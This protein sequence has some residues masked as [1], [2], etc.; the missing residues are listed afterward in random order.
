MRCCVAISGFTFELWCVDRPSYF[1]L[2]L[3]LFF[4]FSI[5]K[6]S[7]GHKWRHFLFK[8]S[9]Q[10]V[11]YYG[12]HRVYTTSLLLKPFKN[13]NEITS[14]WAIWLIIPPKFSAAFSLRAKWANARG[15]AP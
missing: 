13:D 5:E 3:S 11:Q 6:T 2:S 10:A 9:A 12:A 1:S 8:F 14:S 4:K 7:R 15:M